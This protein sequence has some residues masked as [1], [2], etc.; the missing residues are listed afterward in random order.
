[1]TNA[2]VPVI[3]RWEPLP[4]HEQQH[5][6]RPLQGRHRPADHTPV[7]ATA[8]VAATGSDPYSFVFTDANTLYVADPTGIKKYWFN[9]TAW[10]PEGSATAPGQLAGLTGRVEG[11][12]VQLYATD[13]AGTKVYAFTD[14]AAS[15]ATILGSFTPIL[16]APANTVLR[17]VAFA[18]AGRSHRR[19]RPQFSSATRRSAA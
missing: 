14:S 3:S 10:T 16:T 12:V 13:L 15:N 5:A 6:A 18:P 9:G 4:E 19:R 1:M 17:G 7:T 8:L 11:P 2:R